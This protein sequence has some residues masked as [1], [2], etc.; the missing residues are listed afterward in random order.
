MYS[1]I[2]D[3]SDFLFADKK[4]LKKY[5]DDYRYL[6]DTENLKSKEEEYKNKYKF[7]W[8]MNAALNLSKNTKFYSIYFEYLIENANNS[9]AN[10]GE[11]FSQIENSDAGFQFSFV[12]KAVHMIN[13]NLPI[14]DI[15]IRKFYFFAE[16]DSTKTWEKK[17]E[18]A[19]EYYEFLT[20]EYK[21]IIEN[22]LLK[23]TLDK[24]DIF[25]NSIDKLDS[26]SQVKKIDS[27][28][29]AWVDFLKKG[30]IV[31]KTTILE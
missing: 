9:N 22:D 12:S 6:K 3:N 11:L 14:Y 5:W 15:N 26:I 13:P 10:I 1:I 19:N 16:I 30:A 25:L 18:K 29:W 28:I 4:K 24:L 17:L 2:N 23:V 8:G 31:N 27:I 20:F 21:R 7:F